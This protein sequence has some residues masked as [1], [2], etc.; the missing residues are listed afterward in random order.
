MTSEPVTGTP[1]PDGPSR[2]EVLRGGGVLAG[3]TLGTGLLGP[4]LDGLVHP[5]PAA[6][7]AAGDPTSSAAP[8]GPVRIREATNFSMALSPDGRLIAF[9][10]LSSIWVV[11]ADGG[12]ARRLTGDLQDASRP[13]WSPDGKRVAFQSY[14]D[15]NYHLWL[16]GTDGTGLRQLTRGRFDH[17]EP[18][19][20]P[21]GRQLAFSTDRDGSYGIWLLDVA[22]AQ[23]RP[24]TATPAE[25]AMP[26]WS[27]DG[28]SLAFTV[29]EGAVDVLDLAS[30]RRTRAVTA[31]AGARVY[32]PA[33]TADGRALSHVQLLGGRSDLMLGDRALT[34]GEDVFGFPARWLSPEEVM[35]TAD[36]RIR[37]RTVGMPKPARSGTCRSSSP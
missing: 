9:D 37:R 6:A 7:S 16:A 22:T 24:L 10:A 8:H 1:A 12:D 18:A 33:F 35:Y 2:R 21:D 36:G 4:A 19:F 25:E 20:S 17:R 32:G 13:T 31:P 26:A 14:R 5:A 30:G 23:V 28:G 27:P 29:D 3:A 11:P 34:D 15:G